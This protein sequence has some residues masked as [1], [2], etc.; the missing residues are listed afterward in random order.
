MS[1]ILQV[2]KGFL[3]A[4][5][6]L[7]QDIDIGALCDD[8]ESEMAKGLSSY[9]SGSSLMMIPTFIKIEDD[10]PVDEPVIVI[11]AGGTNLRVALVRF[12]N[13][14]RCVVER[15]ENHPMPGS[16]GTLTKDEF[17]DRLCGYI[18]PLLG[19]SRKIGFC[20]SYPVAI[21]P[22]RDGRVLFLSKE[23]RVDGLV[24]ELLNQN[25]L[26]AIAARGG[27]AAGPGRGK[28]SVVLLNDTVA[29]LLGG[30]AA[31]P[32]RA[33]DGYIGF[34]LGTGTNTAYVEDC[35]NIGKLREA[36]PDGAEPDCASMVVNTESGTFGMAPR[37]AADENLDRQT[38][39]PGKYKFEKAIS[40]AYQ[41]ALLKE[42]IA[43]ASADGLFPGGAGE[44][45]AKIER[46]RARDI[47]LF[48]DYPFGDNVLA[49]ACSGGG[50]GVANGCQRQAAEALYYIIDAM[51]ERIAVFVT[52]SLTSI[53]R[54]TGRGK[55]PC[56][57]VCVT[58]DGTTFYKSKMM[59]SKLDYHVRRY[60]NDECGFYCEFVKAENGVLAGTA[61]AA[62]QNCE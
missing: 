22:N 47:D 14:L 20:F 49:A 24:G 2:V 46:L 28:E 50:A 33:F 35:K 7:A 6:L 1:E 5:G 26:N 32:G 58:A 23:V 59:R 18:E 29:T 40:G 55:N 15:F 61:I 10:I 36:L 16:N 31:Y 48:L 25:L 13:S 4:R 21:L 38:K 12:D 9:N 57:P 42:I 60:M 34:I 30:K 51:F 62:L 43:L 44:R 3:R 53:I 45:L 19:E 37:S 54:R 17:F 39:D 8:F 41:G 27:A 56:A 11:D 52:A